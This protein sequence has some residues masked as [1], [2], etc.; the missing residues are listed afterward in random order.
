MAIKKFF[1]SIRNYVLLIIQLVIPAL[2]V[3]ITMLA[4]GLSD[5]DQN[6]P[7]LAISFNEYLETV[8]TMERGL[9]TSG[10][11]VDRISAS[12]EN[13]INSQSDVHTLRIT[14]RDFEDEILDQYRTS[15]SDTNLY[16]MIGVSFSEAEIKAW[17]NNQGYH[18]AALAVN[19]IN[20]AI[21]K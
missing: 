15:L 14:T 4:D 10:S 2:F 1:Y 8:T 5:G 16:H 6:L 20:N 13:F 21:L 11:M 19:T 3:I 9:I 17:F 18:T 12:Y 7:E